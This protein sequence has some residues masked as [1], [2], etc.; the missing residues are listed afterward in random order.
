MNVKLHNAAVGGRRLS[1]ALRRSRRRESK[2]RRNIAASQ[3]A[4]Y[5]Q[6]PRTR[7]VR[8][9]QPTTLISLV[10]LGEV[11]LGTVAPPFTERLRPFLNMRNRNDCHGPT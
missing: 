2:S 9:E 11:I 6:I 3:S 1:P 5:R 4:D 10:R 7:F 8:S